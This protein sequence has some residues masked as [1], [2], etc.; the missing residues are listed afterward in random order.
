MI[1]NQLN[2]INRH[3]FVRS[4]LQTRG[5]NETIRSDWR[6]QEEFAVMSQKRTDH[7]AGSK[8]R[9]SGVRMLPPPSNPTPNNGTGFLRSPVGQEVPC[10]DA[11]GELPLAVYLAT[12]G[13]SLQ[14]E[15]AWMII[16]TLGEG[17]KL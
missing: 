8:T 9:G 7:A 6:P 10:V 12:F 16:P 11:T 14:S 15:F 17:V 5:R 4:T 13:R 2:L 3:W 1:G